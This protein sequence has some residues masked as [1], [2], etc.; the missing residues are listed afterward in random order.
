MI[1]VAAFKYRAFI[2]YSHAD[3]YSLLAPPVFRDRDGVLAKLDQIGA[4]PP[5]RRSNQAGGQLIKAP[6]SSAGNRS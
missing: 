3:S 5:A 6:S 1:D 4:A 2:S